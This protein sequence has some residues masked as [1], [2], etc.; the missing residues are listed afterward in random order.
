MTKNKKLLNMVNGG[1]CFGEMA[2]I[3]GGEQPR[4]ATVEAMSELLLAE[5]EPA[6]LEKMSLGAQLHL[7]RAL[8]RN[9]TD[10]L[11]LA[12]VRLAEARKVVQAPPW[13]ARLLTPLIARHAARGL[14][15]KYPGLG[16]QEIAEKLRADFR[17]PPTEDEQ[18][19]LDA[20]VSRLPQEGTPAPSVEKPVSAWVLLAANLIPVAGVLLWGWSVFALLALFWMENVIIGAFFALRML[21]ADPRDAA[22]WAAKLFMVPFF[23][24]HY[25]MF[26]AIHGVFVFSLF[27]GKSYSASGLH[28][29]EPA[30][31]AASEL[32]LWLPLGALLASHAFSFLWN[33]LVARRIPPRLPSRADGQAIRSRGGAARRHHP[34]RH[35]CDGARLAG[36]GIARA[37]CPQ[38]RP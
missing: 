26:T 9:V 14:S 25:G 8:V 22:L 30:A 6:A 34:R 33:Y 7:T 5:F 23:C 36:M 20:V 31:R 32:G 10:R 4:H 15:E 27:G 3:G 2:Y 24:F 37:A 12:N 16:P 21:C 1:E 11:A 19:L 29:L 35:R 38:D 18:R 17:N 13:L 28:V